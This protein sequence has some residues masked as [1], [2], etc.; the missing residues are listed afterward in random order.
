MTTSSSRPKRPGKPAPYTLPPAIEAFLEL[1]LGPGF[2][3]V[4]ALFDADPVEK[5]TLQ[6]RQTFYFEALNVMTKADWNLYI[7]FGFQQFANPLEYLKCVAHETEDEYE[8]RIY[9]YFR[10][11]QEADEVVNVYLN[12]LAG[13]IRTFLCL[14]RPFLR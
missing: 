11:H 12:S 6:L 10:L 13:E 7:H 4:P 8:I 3:A 9:R 2:A 1:P 5:S 14:G